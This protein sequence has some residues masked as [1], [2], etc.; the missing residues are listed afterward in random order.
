MLCDMK[1]LMQRG[2]TLYHLNHTLESGSV[3]ERYL[4]LQEE[5]QEMVRGKVW[6][7]VAFSYSSSADYMNHQRANDNSLLPPAE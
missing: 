6:N 1:N 5:R 4:E 2:E 3:M 7:H